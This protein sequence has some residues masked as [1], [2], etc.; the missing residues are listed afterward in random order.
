LR[1]IAVQNILAES[2]HWKTLGFV[3]KF[4]FRLK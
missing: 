1:I 2:V 3:D 4:Q